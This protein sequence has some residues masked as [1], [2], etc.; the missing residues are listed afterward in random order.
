MQ[1][2]IG[3]ILG[4][5]GTGKTTLCRWLLKRAQKTLILDTLGDDYGNGCI[6]DNGPEFREY[7]ARVRDGE[8]FTVILRPQS[9][10]DVGAFFAVA[11][12]SARCWIVVEEI[13]RYCTAGAIEDENLN[14]V[15]NYGRHRELNLIGLARRPARVNRSL[16]ANADWIISHQTTEP[17]DLQYLSEFMPIDEVPSLERGEWVMW[18]ETELMAGTPPLSSPQ[19]SPEPSPS[20]QLSIS[21]ST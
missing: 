14:W 15:I 4:R 5:K 18:G 20:S 8:G 2:E 19:D 6:C 9:D 17:R 3:V 21:S 1:N 11:R 16:T 13:D 12:A 7:A 10:A